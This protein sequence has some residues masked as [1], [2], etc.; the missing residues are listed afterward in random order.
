[1]S[2]LAD[3]VTAEIE[4]LQLDIS[5]SARDIEEIC[6]R[7]ATLREQRMAFLHATAISDVHDDPDVMRAHLQQRLMHSVT[8]DIMRDSAASLRF[9]AQVHRSSLS[10]LLT[11]VPYL[12]QPDRDVYRAYLHGIYQAAKLELDA[13]KMEEQAL[14]HE[15]GLDKQAALTEMKKQALLTK[16]TKPVAKDAKS[17]IFVQS[18]AGGQVT[19][20][21]EPFA[22]KPPTYYGAN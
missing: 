6:E 8:G 1:M 15:V 5:S 19:Y 2:S 7:I 16:Y 18:Q 20:Q 11:D 12:E 9:R 17:I 10:A 22:T 13:I 21:S 4:T 14:R 3:I